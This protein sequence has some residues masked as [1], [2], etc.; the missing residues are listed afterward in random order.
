MKTNSHSETST[1]KGLVLLAL[2]VFAGTFGLMAQ[3]FERD[4]QDG[5][6]YF[7]FKDNVNL[8]ISVRSDNSV[9]FEDIPFIA[10]LQSVYRLKSLERP[11]DLN[12]DSKLLRTFMLEIEDIA[13]INQVL[14]E[15]QIE[16]ELE[17]VEKV[18]MDYIHYVPNDTLYNMYNGPSN[19]NWHMDVIQAE[20]A[21]EITK[22]SSE[23]KVAIVDNA[24]WVDHPDLADKIVLQRD[25]YYNTNNANPPTSGDPFDWSHGTHCA[26]L[27]AAITDNNT[28][29]S[30]IG[31][32]VSIIAVKAANNS[33]ANGIYGYPGIQ[34]AAN[35]GADVIN[36]SWGG[37]GY[38][39]TNQNLI[40][41]IS[42]MGVVLLASAGNDNV[43]TPHYPSGYNNIISIASTD[44]DDRKSDFSNYGTAVDLC[45]PGGISTTGPSGLLSTTYNSNTYGYYDLMAG[46]SMATPVA[47]GLVGLILSINP[48]LTPAQVETILKT[49]A[50]DIEA[51][52]PDY[53]G[54]LGSGRI[55]AYQAV[56]NTPF[57]PTANFSTPVTTILPGGG[58]DFSDLSTGVPSTW[59]W[60]FQG[61]TPSSSAAAN[62]TNIK[63]NS[64]GVYDV[65]LTVTNQFG[66]HTLTLEDYI[67]ATNTPAPYIGFSANNLTPCIQ[68]VVEMSDLSLYS[69]TAWSWTVS[70]DHFEF[71]NGTSSTS[72]NPQIQ[73]LLPG[74]YSVEFT[75]TNANGS[76]SVNE[77]DFI[78]VYGAVPSYTIDMEDGTSG[79]FMVWDTI[80]SQSKIDARSAF[81]SNFGIHFH[82]DPVPTGWSGSPTSGT[83]TQAWETNLGFHGK[84]HI[85][86]VDGT[87]LDNIALSFDLRQTYSL[88]PRF[89]WF[90]VLVNGEQIADESGNTD[91]N[92]LTAAADPWTRLTYDLSAYAGTIFDVTLQSATRFSDKTQGEGDNV[93][94]DNISITNTTNTKPSVQKSSGFRIYPNPSDGRFTIASDILEGTYNIKVLSLLGNSVYS[95][96][97]DSNG[98]LMRAIDLSHL[99]A[100]VYLINISNENQNFNQR[101]IIR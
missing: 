8:N 2:L 29:I 72:Q 79:Y 18:P 93:F 39:A 45:A 64:P 27:A 37:P 16:S 77:T 99:P 22:G 31:F 47:V 23:I 74:L 83:A 26:G 85:C 6:L 90:R 66:T 35:N 43:S 94:I 3:N 15:L 14:Q 13:M 9:A 4:Y 84:V 95:A 42:N 33:N 75:A 76:S 21:W 53:T 60:T 44:S 5:R 52:N 97:G 48:A 89:S 1:F 70:P 78:D 38:S 69:P 59:Q 92:P 73:F 34:W 91:F 10:D 12:Q 32:N 57:Q 87:D 68:D 40:N 88:G 100:G 54:Q 98:R 24:V 36:M 61:G 96:S 30:A 81:E 50:D 7:K 17:Y 19:W 80:K 101:I 49:T 41:T 63:F 67:T 55:N 82:G 51:L 65:T 71:V 56:L 11:F 46:T 58:V 28:G 25:T 86:G 62:P 20:Q